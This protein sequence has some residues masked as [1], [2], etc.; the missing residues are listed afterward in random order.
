[1]PEALNLADDRRPERRAQARALLDRLERESPF[2][3]AP[4]VGITGAPGSGKS[5][6]LD[7]LVRRLRAK[8]ETVAIVAVD[9]S[10]RTTGGALLGD[11]IRVRSA[12][13]DPGVF[14][15]SMAARERLGGISDAARAGVAILAPVFDHVFVE[16]V[17]VGQSESE[18]T[19]IVDTLVFVASPG[20]GDVLQFIKAGLIELPD[21]FAV[22]KADL[23]EVAAQTAHELAG[24]L[25]LGAR[26]PGAWRPPVLLVSARDGTGVDALLEAIRAHG[27]QQIASSRLR[28]RRRAGLEDAVLAQLSLRYGSHGLAQLGGAEGVRTRLRRSDGTTSIALVEAIGAEIESALRRTR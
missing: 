3:G 27:A 4:R 11:R 1:M 2:P 21:V 28:A 23:G 24:A 5:T 17:G 14:V 18:V 26:E 9:P 22:N 16:T 19:S 13:S 25:D 20:A 7:A 15:R 6:L 12:A 8:G 10:S